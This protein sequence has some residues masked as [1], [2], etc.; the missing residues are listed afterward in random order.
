M[1]PIMRLGLRVEGL[2]LNPVIWFSLFGFE[3]GSQHWSKSR[4]QRH[5][6]P[7]S[8]PVGERAITLRLKARESNSLNPSFSPESKNKLPGLNS[9]DPPQPPPP[10]WHSQLR[11]RCDKGDTSKCP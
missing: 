1:K 11:G 8:V 3:V 10:C 5:H 4:A 6:H 2:G 9:G 7:D